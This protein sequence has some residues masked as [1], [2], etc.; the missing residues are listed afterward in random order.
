MTLKLQTKPNSWQ[1]LVTSFAMAYRVPVESLITEIGH[2]GSERVANLPDPQGR[3]GYHIQECISVGIDFGWTITP[4]ELCP[5]SLVGPHQVPIGVR[6]P[7]F[8]RLLRSTVGV[9]TCRTKFG[10]HHAVAYEDG[11]IYDPDGHIGNFE[12]Y[13]N[14]PVCL[15]IV[16]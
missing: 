5:V 9:M 6:S 12:D 3:R 13:W 4:F 14:Y 7:M 2:D 11:T 1:C 8:N 16:R 15:W 10:N